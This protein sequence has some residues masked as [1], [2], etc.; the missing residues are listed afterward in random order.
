MQKRVC[1]EI[2]ISKPIFKLTL[3]TFTRDNMRNYYQLKVMQTEQGYIC[4]NISL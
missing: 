3:F 4:I 2:F 1:T